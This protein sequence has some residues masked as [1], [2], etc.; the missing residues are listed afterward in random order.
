[1]TPVAAWFHAVFEFL[2]AMLAGAM[3]TTIED[4]LT[5]HAVPNHAAA[6]VCAGGRQGMD[7]AFKAIEHMRLTTH[8]DFKT[9]VVHVPAHFTSHLAIISHGIYSFPSL[10]SLLLFVPSGRLALS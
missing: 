6:A 8:A 10:T 7:G 5:F 4:A 3:R 1:M 2:D 9:F